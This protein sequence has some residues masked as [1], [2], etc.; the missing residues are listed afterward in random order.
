MTDISPSLL[1]VKLK[2][3]GVTYETRHDADAVL[4]SEWAT[5]TKGILRHGDATSVDAAAADREANIGEAR[6]LANAA[7]AAAL[8]CKRPDWKPWEARAVNAKIA[9]RFIRKVR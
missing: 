6:R 1:T 5:D 7:A 4:A 9:L 2:L 8:V 3:H